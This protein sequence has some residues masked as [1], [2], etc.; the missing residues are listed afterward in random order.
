MPTPPELERY[1]DLFQEFGLVAVGK[2]PHKIKNAEELERWGLVVILQRDPNVVELS[3][4]GKILKDF[5]LGTLQ[6]IE[7]LYL[8]RTTATELGREDLEQPQDRQPELGSSR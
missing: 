5:Y 7:G 4:R 3:P 2:A 6:D 8:S 1:A